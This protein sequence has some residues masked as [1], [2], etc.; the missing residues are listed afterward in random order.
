M[1]KMIKDDARAVLAG[2]CC[3]AVVFMSTTEDVN[4]VEYVDI[5]KIIAYNYG[6]NFMTEYANYGYDKWKAD[7]D[8]FMT[9][10]FIDEYIDTGVAP[11][12]NDGRPELKDWLEAS[13]KTGLFDPGW[14]HTERTIL[15]KQ[16]IE[17]MLEAYPADKEQLR[18]CISYLNAMLGSTVDINWIYK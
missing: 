9:Q 2:V 15:A 5:S 14:S 12:L 10:S 1:V 11:I 16:F 7:G 3:V 4:G 17:S 18:D 8:R 13:A 6:D